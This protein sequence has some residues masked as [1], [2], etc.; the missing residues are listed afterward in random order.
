MFPWYRSIL[1]RDLDS[2]AARPLQHTQHLGWRT[3]GHCL[4][5]D[6]ANRWGLFDW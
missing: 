6:F 1:Q 4:W 2:A 3:L 5:L